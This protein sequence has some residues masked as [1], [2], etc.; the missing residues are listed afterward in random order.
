MREDLR[1]LS[2]SFTLREA[3][4]VQSDFV[5]ELVVFEILLVGP[6]GLVNPNVDFH[7]SS[8]FLEI[9]KTRV[10]QPIRTRE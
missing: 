3:T 8:H 5:R 2:S 6:V 9:E 7:W 10:S 1:S 4:G